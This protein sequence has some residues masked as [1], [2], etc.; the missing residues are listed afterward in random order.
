MGFKFF[1]TLL[2]LIVSA[3]LLSGAYLEQRL[4]T[5]F[6]ERLQVQM[7]ERVAMAR[8]LVELA[9]DLSGHADKLADRLGESSSDRVTIIGKNGAVTGDSRLS[10]KQLR[11]V[12]N[13]AN[14]PE[15]RQALSEG[16]GVSRR[17]S[18]TVQMDMLYV[19]LPFER[20]RARGVVRLSKPLSEV[21]SAVNQLRLVLLV[22]GLIGLALAVVVS[23]L[24]SYL[25]AKPLRRLVTSLAT[26]KDRLETIL[27]GMT[28]AVLAIDPNKT[29]ASANTATRRLLGSPEWR[30]GQK[31]EDVGAGLSLV[32]WVVGVQ[33]G[34]KESEET[35]LSLPNDRLALVRA[36]RLRTTG[37][38]VVVML[39][40]TETRRLENVR[41]DFVANVSHELRTPVSV[42][43]ANAETLLDGALDDPVHGPRFVEAILRSAER[44]SRLVGDLL[45]LSRIESGNFA[46]ELTR[47]SVSEEVQ[48]VVDDLRGLASDQKLELVAD[49]PPELGV[50]ADASALEQVLTNLIENALKYTPSPG[51]VAISAA[52]SGD[53]RFVTV[54]ISDTGPGID[55][56]HRT[57]IFERFYRVDTGRSRHMGGTGLGLS[58][59]KHLVG[60]LR[61][62]VKVTERPGGGSIFQVKLQA[63]T[64]AS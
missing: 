35:E 56:K 38:L 9:G 31:L 58:I 5:W 52:P 43:R 40:I 39:D 46:V 36:A 22:A 13:H 51:S 54:S 15:I 10:S 64:P 37:G 61:G 20:D 21:E 48:S 41:R 24:A 7:L 47:L 19:A 62:E 33:E 17:Y 8:D 27:E 4:R 53:G 55:K 23:G 30:E 59:V 49:I 34:T 60:F 45:D 6:D 18:R 26:E 42:I 32:D 3:G 50:L 2:A 12:E 63:T 16:K 11:T 57:R 44:Q 14:R 28:E 29:I 1:S 25:V